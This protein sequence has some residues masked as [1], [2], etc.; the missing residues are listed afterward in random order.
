MARDLGMLKEKADPMAPHVIPYPLIESF[1]QGKLK[2]TGVLEA[3]SKKVGRLDSLEERLSPLALRGVSDEVQ[4]SLGSEEIVIY[5][6]F[7][8]KTLQRCRGV[9]L[10]PSRMGNATVSTRGGDSGYSR[11]EKRTEV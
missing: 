11:K 6:Q 1:L 7:E 3:V 4:K 10:K 5:N 2:E 9:R 8:G